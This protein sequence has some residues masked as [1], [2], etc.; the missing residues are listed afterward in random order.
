MVGHACD[1]YVAGER[2]DDNARQSLLAGAGKRA[3]WIEI[4]QA[5]CVV[6]D[7]EVVRDDLDRAVQ[8]GDVEQ[9]IVGVGAGIGH[10]RDVHRQLQAAGDFVDHIARLHRDERHRQVGFPREVGE[11]G[12]GLSRRAKVRRAARRDPQIEPLVRRQIE[13]GKIDRLLLAVI[14]AET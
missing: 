5:G 4:Q 14:V 1:E 8:L 2:I 3:R 11:V 12:F 13:R 9:R 10:E 7:R 6:A